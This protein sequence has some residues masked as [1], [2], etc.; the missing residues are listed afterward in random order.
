MLLLPPARALLHVLYYPLRTLTCLPLAHLLSRLAH[1]PQ[2]SPSIFSFCCYVVCFPL[3]LYCKRGHTALMLAS[4]KGHT[5]TVELLL[6]A[7]AD[8]DAKDRVSET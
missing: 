8:K 4:R 3:S 2:S 1:F 5:A 7:G 6:G